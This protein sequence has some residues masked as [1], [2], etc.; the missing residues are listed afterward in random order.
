M[1]AADG[2]GHRAHCTSR[3]AG[4]NR[5]FVSH[6][7]L[8]SMSTTPVA[9]PADANATST[10]PA[11]IAAKPA[12]AFPRDLPSLVAAPPAT[13]QRIALA[14][15]AG[16]ADALAIAELASAPDIA[17]R[18]VA[19]V[20]ADALSAQRLVDE[21]AWFAPA[22][23]VAPFPDWETLPY[24]HF[25]PH[26]DLVSERLATLY[27]LSRGECD[28]VVV[29][30]STAL[31]RLVPA[32]YLAARTFFLSQGTK[33]DVDGLRAQLALAGY[34]HVTQVVAPGEF[35]VRGGL[36]DLF[37][38]GSAVPYRLDLFGDEIESIK[39]FDVDTQ[40]TLYPM[41]DV[42]LLP[43]REFPLDEEG[44]SR[45]R[46][47]FREVFE[48]DPSKTGIYRD[49]SNGIAPGGIEYWLP[50]FFDHTAMFTDYLPPATTVVMHNDVT[51]A[52]E[53]FWQD[54]DARYRLLRGEKSRPLPP[55][56]VDRRATDPLAALKAFIASTPAR[57]AICAD[58]AGRR[59][60]M[61]QFFAEYGV[62]PLVSDGFAAFV[63]DPAQRL[64]LI[65]APLHAGFAW[66]DAGLV[67]VTEAELY[68]GTVRRTRRDAARRS[69]VDAMVRD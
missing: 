14:P 25:S 49:I 17:H 3:G 35:S 20:C 30:A 5:R 7:M 24:D 61:Q 42:R 57:V 22:L 44:R 8:H 66:P 10:P 40:R 2:V 68:A 64:A 32:E 60:T 36:I 6:V 18:T 58:T 9:T 15:L 13:G 63:A 1:M 65:A 52:V 16:S 11:A 39:T 45:F 23:R 56:A 50:L 62:R 41:R 46:S 28:V 19:V 26:Q 4:Y 34:Q 53:Q 54:T 48:G 33:L 37:P 27:R 38:T 59:E 29:T 21:I 55:L 43:A 12:A 31:Y 69:N 47:R 67:F 51:H